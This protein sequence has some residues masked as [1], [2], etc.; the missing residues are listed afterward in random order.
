MPRPD[1]QALRRDGHARGAQGRHLF[2]EGARVDD[3]AV[4]EHSHRMRVD[5]AGW[6]EM[7]FE[8]LASN[9]DGVT[10]V[11]SAV[12]TRHVVGPRGEIIHDAPF[13]L[14]TPLSAD[15]DIQRHET[16]CGD[17][18]ISE[19]RNANASHLTGRESRLMDNAEAGTESRLGRCDAFHNAG[20][21]RL[22]GESKRMANPV[23]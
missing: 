5:D 19:R 14:I 17:W 9:R 3:H 13:A 15:N 11:V 18:I 10:G 2:D 1:V 16:S 6:H 12:V 7:K 22:T 23:W 20:D 4:A 8:D 21:A